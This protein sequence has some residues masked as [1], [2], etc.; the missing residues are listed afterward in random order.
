ME[1]EMMKMTMKRLL[2]LVLVVTMVLTMVP[3]TFVSA[4]EAAKPTFSVDNVA[5]MAGESVYVPV[6]I[7]DNTG[8]GAVVLRFTLPEGW[9]MESI[10]DFY[11]D[12]DISILYDTSGRFPTT[13]YNP[14]PNVSGKSFTIAAKVTADVTA[15]GVLCW[16]KVGIP[17]NAA[18]GKYEIGISSDAVYKAADAST[19]V[20]DSFEFAA[21]EVDV[22]AAPRPTFSVDSVDA[23][24]GTSF[25]AP[26]RIVNNTGFGA[27]VLRFALPE[28][29]TLES[30]DDFYGDDDISILYDTSGRFP[31]TNYN[32]TPNVPGKS[33]TIAAKVTADVT[34]NGVLCWLKVLA[35]ADAV[36]GAYEIGVSSDAVYKAADASTNVI[37]DFDFAAGIIN[38]TGGV[39]KL[40][41]E[42]TTVT[43][44]EESY[45]YNGGG[46]APAPVVTFNGTQLTAGTDY[47]VFYS[48]NVNVGTVTVTVTG[49]GHYAGSLETTF[50]ITPADAAI[51]GTASYTKTYGAADFTLDAAATSGAALSYASDNEA[52]AK[53]DADGKVTVLGAGTAN[54]TVSAEATENYN[55]PANFTVTVNVAKAQQVLSGKNSYAKTYGDA[56]FELEV[57]GAQGTLSYSTNNP[58][59]ATVHNGV[60]TVV[61]VGNATITVNAAEV[62][63]KYEADSMTVNV[64][65]AKKTVTVSGITAAGKVYDKTTDAVVST[66]AAVINGKV[67]GDDVTVNATGTFASA[68]AG[69]KTVNLTVT[70]TGSDADKYVLAS[71]SQKTATATIEKAKVEVPTAKTGL[72]YN[73]KSQTALESTAD[74]TVTGGTATNAGDYEA[75]VTLKDAANYQWKTAFSGKLEWSIA[76]ADAAAMTKEVSRRYTSTE[77]ITVSAADVTL[78]QPGKVTL[79]NWKVTGD[80]L[81]GT[82]GNYALKSGLTSADAGK[83]A[84]IT[85][86]VASDN[87]ETTTLTVT[88]KVIDKNNV[89]EKM[90]FADGSGKY[91]GVAHTYEAAKYNGSS[92]GIKYTYSEDPIN[93]GTY[94]VTAVYEDADNYG[95]ATA[96]YTIKP[97]NVTVSAVE[98]ADKTYDGKTDAEVTKVTFKGL[99]NGETLTEADYTVTDVAFADKNVGKDKTVT[100]TVA[101]AE[102]A[103]T[104]NYVLTGTMPAAKAEIKAKEVTVSGITAEDKDYDGSTTATVSTAAATVAG[105]VDG[106][107]LDITAEGKFENATAGEKTVNLTVKLNGADAGNY[108]LSAD[109]QKTASATIRKIQVEVPAAK[110]GLVYNTKSQTAVEATADY[111][112]TGATATNAGDYEATV[113]LKDAANYEWK[114]EFSGNLAWSIAKADAAA[115]TKEVSRRFTST[116]AV[117]VTAADVTLDQPGKVTL[118]NWKVTG[119]IL[120][121]TDGSYALKSGLTAADAGKTA[122]I[123]VDVDSDNYNKT[124]LTV[125][126]KVI[127]KNNVSEKMTFADGSGKYTGVAHTYEAAKY[128]GSS[129]GIKYSYS[130]DPIN[131][132]TYTVTAVYEDADN[133]G[134]ATAK[135]TINPVDVTVSAVEVADKTYDGKTDAEVTKVTF[136]G[137]VNGET[138]TEEDYTVTAAFT[139]KNVG[140]DKAVNY[141]VALAENAKTANYVLTGTMPAAKA[142]IKAKEVTVSGITAEDKDYDGNTTATVNYAD[143]IVAGKIEGENLAITAVGAFEN[144]TAGEKTVNLTVKLMGADAGNYVLSADS[145]KTAAATIRKIQVEVPAAKEGLVYNTKSQTALEATADYTVENGSA[146]NAG[147]YE[148]VVTLKD[149][150]NH[151]W[152]TQFDGKLTWSIAKADAAAMTKEVSRRFNSTEAITV[153][154]AD[155][156]LDQPGKVTLS[157]WKVTGDI[158]T[159]TDGNYVLKSG[160]TS[161][162]AGKTAT[163]TVDVDSDNYNKTTL[164]LTVKVID[165]NNVSEKLTFADG[166]GVYT[167]V[168]H[169][170]EAAKFNGAS[171]GFRYS[172]SADPVNVGTYTV[173]AVYEDAENYGEVTAKYTVTAAELSVENAEVTTKTYDGSTDAEV[174]NV[175]FRGLVNGETLTAD[176]YTVSNAAFADKNAGENKAVNYT[177]ALAENAKTANYVLTGTVP[178]AKGEIEAKAVTVSGI[179]A[180]DKDYD[181]TTAASVNTAAATVEGKLEGD[182]VTV[183]AA[184]AFE[185]ANAGEK[186]VNLTVTLGGADAGNYVLSADS[187]KTAA[188]TIRKAKVEAP[189]AK[190]GLVYNGEEQTAVAAAA[191][192]EVANGSATNAGSYE[193]VVTLK[194]EVNTEW[195][196]DFSGKLAWSIAK[197]EPTATVKKIT[198][199]YDGKKLTNADID[200]TASCEGV[201]SWLTDCDDMVNVG[202]YDATVLFTPTD[203]VNYTAVE[204]EVV[205]T[206]KAQEVQAPEIDDEDAET[207]DDLL[208]EE[209]FVDEDGNV[210]EGELTWYDA[211]GKKVMGDA[212]IEA[213]TEYTWIFVPATDNYETV[214]G[215]YE[216]DDAAGSLNG[217]IGILG[218]AAGTKK[219]DDVSRTDWFYDAVNYVVKEG[220]FEGVSEDEFR[221]NG[222]MTRAMLVTVL[223]RLE[224]E[225][226][227]FWYSDFEDVSAYA[228]YADAVAWASANGI[229]NGV[230]ATEFDPDAPITREQMAAM[231]YRYAGFKG[232]D[233]SVDGDLNAYADAEDVSDYAKDAM[234]WAVS[235]G[236]IQGM[237]ETT[238]APQGTATRAQVATILMRFNKWFDL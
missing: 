123:T 36:N 141:T 151:E 30:I 65:V 66:A 218:G 42:N 111:T 75:T 37:A 16:L 169:T 200:G 132:G 179:T 109:S 237:N 229:V 114:T 162:D 122:T 10:D 97:V 8:F 174:T 64:S 85:V 112:V 207:L 81:T 94:T 225:P 4:D 212:Q 15:N 102:N 34:A 3:G 236:F 217:L 213:G 215:T 139:A 191:D 77:A 32:P 128:N 120:T 25:Y 17:A 221:P 180:A 164:T 117:N 12:E 127:D 224:G 61:G 211:D 199:T 80:V 79:S 177:V 208:S 100:Y 27:V 190:T 192:Y 125:T 48:D 202:K 198:K 238:L 74:Y 60:V 70:L 216:S 134:E 171:T 184:G 133:Y 107:K 105:V 83:T 175:T 124:T 129:A 78:D 7:T 26:V 9:T 181:K 126:V 76:K 172:Y 67:A 166:T 29:W 90:T 155:V 68:T 11:G 119:D 148:A 71:N 2:S 158:L 118:S 89:S 227:V 138:L 187:Q 57:E 214:S 39:E 231:L 18:G 153:S 47:D 91:T 210:I 98:V 165:K 45:T 130:A 204:V 201:F 144:A 226:T 113:T 185:D 209:D 24:A 96:K 147:D 73:T 72:V 195:K 194:D 186:T 197:A 1:G 188:A 33:F 82:N 86:D 156:T 108:V 230:S 92:A 222:S 21:G 59:V 19:N 43:G 110:E 154:A 49:K 84:T 28:G 54:I 206:V 116:E 41:E 69:D 140:K 38:I 193:A 44:I 159:G 46:I 189:T 142:E 173:T 163:V 13:N 170:Y 35:P 93:V 55:A 178:A 22:T 20:I 115:M 176:D 223:W 58:D 168:A 106:E 23:V 104:A 50:E 234:A 88:V 220:L 121:G 161:A 56:A 53:V 137:L 146:V 157:N 203:D 145:Q 196:S 150:V 95:E 5:A 183:I 219:F 228:W 31:T 99:V 14:T 101:L 51:T 233:V 63:G 149:A 6:R 40:T 87:Y 103:K 62:E 143:A 182:V 232:L 136:K 235:N 167:G 205:V 152:K 131:V 135:Y 160:L 52:V